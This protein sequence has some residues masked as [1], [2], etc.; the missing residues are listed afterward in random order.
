MVFCFEG[1]SVTAM[2]QSHTDQ[3]E[4]QKTAALLDRVEP[5]FAS[6]LAGELV[7][8]FLVPAPGRRYRWA[9]P[10]TSLRRFALLAAL[11]R[12]VH[13]WVG[14]WRGWLTVRT[15]L[16][17]SAWIARSYAR[18]LP[19]DHRHLIVGQDFL[20]FLWR[21]GVLAGR[22]FSVLLMR[23]PLGVMHEHFEAIAREF[24]RQT[25]LQ[26]FRADPELVRAEN[27]ALQSAERVI[28][29]HRELGHLFTN[30]RLL[31]WY[32]P[33]VVQP[34]GVR[35]PSYLLFPASLVTR[36]G[37]HAAL[38]AGE[39]LG[40]PLL[41]CGGNPE[42]LT[43]ESD[44]VQFTT[45]SEIPWHQVAVVVHPTLFKT[46]PRLHLQALALGIPVVTTSASGLDE[47]DGVSFVDFNDEDGLV[48]AL[49]RAMAR[50][51]GRDSDRVTESAIDVLPIV[52]EIHDRLMDRELC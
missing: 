15:N 27:E 48:R 22:R 37:A 44:A 5:E 11:A 49:E 19:S 1:I 52:S 36:E 23:P 33:E 46:W 32:R 8:L 35:N 45:D 41:V 21:D 43:F 10:S 39:C 42:A 4:H 24:P 38:A 12:V 25:T 7:D 20:P 47:G 3:V 16:K 28:T 31:E 51:V 34:A 30:L 9:V 14:Q 17:A 29:P 40:L 6:F 13:R 26:T 18:Q 50:E 2:D